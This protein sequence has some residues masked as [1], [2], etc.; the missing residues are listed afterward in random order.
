MY[1]NGALANIQ[2]QGVTTEEENDRALSIVESL[3]AEENL[4]P[5]KEQILRLLVTLI[6]KF[7]DEHYQLAASTP[8]SILLH[9]MEERGLRQAD[10]VGVIGSRGVVSEVVNDKRTISKGQ[11]KSLGEFFH[12]DP[13]LFVD[14]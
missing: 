8:H 12:V 9:L 14:L 11:A 1:N 7:E 13:S 10:L 4:S 6:E 5:E 2:I 3:L